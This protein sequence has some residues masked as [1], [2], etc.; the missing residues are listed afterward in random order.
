[1]GPEIVVLV[2]ASSA[3]EGARIA[4]TLVDEHLIACA[5]MVS[6]LRSFFFWEGKMRDETE[7]LLICKTMQPLIEK[8]IKRV[9]ELHSYSVPEIIALPIVAGSKEYLSWI[10]E[11]VKEQ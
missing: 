1:M 11:T 5:N 3:E 7:T 8:V 2:T 9:K 4:K 10:G 6:G